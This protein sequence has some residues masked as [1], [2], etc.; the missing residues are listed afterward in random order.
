MKGILLFKVHY[1][2]GCCS[3]YSSKKQLLPK[4]TES[5]EILSDG[6]AII[7][8]PAVGYSLVSYDIQNDEFISVLP[9]KCIDDKAKHF[10]SMNFLFRK[11]ATIVEV[12]RG[13]KIAYYNTDGSQI[14]KF[15]YCI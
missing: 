10:D 4:D 8:L 2:N 12:I 7:A 1:K 14:T 13:N 11:D 5:L 3:L 6:T 15:K 9:S